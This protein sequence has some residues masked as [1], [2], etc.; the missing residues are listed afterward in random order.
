MIVENHDTAFLNDIEWR[1]K[2][3][4]FQKMIIIRKNDWHENDMF[5]RTKF[6]TIATTSSIFYQF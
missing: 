5:C 1:D 4:E 3:I 2:W 6:V